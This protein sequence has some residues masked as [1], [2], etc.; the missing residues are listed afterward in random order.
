[1][2]WSRRKQGK[3]LPFVGN[4][5][6][7]ARRMKFGKRLEEDLAEPGW[8][9]HYVR[10]KLLKRVVKVLSLLGR[11]ADS[12]TVEATL[13]LF[14]NRKKRILRGLKDA[15]ISCTLCKR[16]N[17]FSGMLLDDLAHVRSFLS[18]TVRELESS[19]FT[20]I[21]PSVE[22]LLRSFKFKHEPT[23][24][25]GS[26]ET[27]LL[28]RFAF[29]LDTLSA[30]RRFVVVNDMA[31]VKAIKKFRKRVAYSAEL[32][33]ASCGKECARSML[34]KVAS[35]SVLENSSY[36]FSQSPGDKGG[37]GGGEDDDSDDDDDEVNDNEDE[38]DDEMM[39]TKSCRSDDE[40]PEETTK[41]KENK[42]GDI[43]CYKPLIKKLELEC[44]PEWETMKRLEAAA[45]LL[46]CKTMVT[47]SE[48]HDFVQD[49]LTQLQLQRHQE[50]LARCE[51]RSKMLTR[52]TRHIDMENQMRPA[53]FLLVGV[54]LP[55]VTLAITYYI[56]F[57]IYV[58]EEQ[59]RTVFDEKGFF[60]S[61]SI[62]RAPAS[63]IGTLGLTT[64]LTMLSI[65]IFVKHKL[66][67]K[68]LRGR[69]WMRTHRIATAFGL[70]STFCGN[71]VA[72]FQHEANATAHNTF[73][74]LF[75]LFGMI[76][77]VMETLIDY[78]FSLSMPV[79]RKLRL[80]T[81][82][83]LI[84]CVAGFLLPM[85]YV[86]SHR[87]L[88]REVA[89][90]WKQVAAT[91]E[92]GAFVLFC[93]WFASYYA[94]L[95]ASQFK[96]HVQYRVRLDSSENLLHLRLSRHHQRQISSDSLEIDDLEQEE[97]AT[98]DTSDDEDGGTRSHV[99]V[100]GDMGLD[101]DDIAFQEASQ[102]TPFF[103]KPSSPP[104]RSSF[105]PVLLRRRSQRF[106]QNKI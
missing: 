13:D 1:V 19:Y 24:H 4:S 51:A 16:W 47:S 14:P 58:D 23:L 2:I 9:E 96:L 54:I 46:E 25:P 57:N 50:K 67:K 68:Q 104:S 56:S 60:I 43:L 83:L 27:K 45:Y 11:D 10:Y 66:V 99:A 18:S 48:Y 20:E 87:S 61:T 53:T 78:K 17:V 93:L 101:L 95:R 59:Q 15:Q 86:I 79:T 44:M 97:W 5:K 88:D 70:L 29:F 106:T 69:N 33:E 92:V 34:V 31:L 89:R 64:T 21:Q 100:D 102:K 35:A 98:W 77:V 72:A 7:L 74:G 36:D 91:F 40:V 39:S 71:G 103:S 41:T 22:E 80:L 42:N 26:E 63:N 76:H 3:N 37:V 28:A 105:L 32:H 82:A 12:Q 65:I 81:S 75:F 30:L 49:H 73:A 90:R 85:S 84:F 8:E 55:L 62:D 52:L 6:H 38:D 94:V